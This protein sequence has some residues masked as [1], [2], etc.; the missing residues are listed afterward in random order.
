MIEIPPACYNTIL[1]QSYSHKY[2]I[3]GVLAGIHHDSEKIVTTVY[4]TT[5]AA[6]TPRTRYEIDPEELIGILERIHHTAY[7]VIGFYHS[8]PNGPLTPS[9]AD[10][11]QATWSGHSYVICSYDGAQ[12]EYNRSMSEYPSDTAPIESV[13]VDSCPVGAYWGN[14]NTN[15]ETETETET[16]PQSTWNHQYLPI[17][18]DTDP[19]HH[20]GSWRW[21]GNQFHEETIVIK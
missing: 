1:A 11:A 6:E 4:P 12:S 20:L 2:E 21:D 10:S 3:C 18:T 16:D 14:N 9:E 5:N 8:H 15:D 17:S 7:E 13:S 19:T